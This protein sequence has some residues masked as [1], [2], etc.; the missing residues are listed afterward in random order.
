MTGGQR[1]EIEALVGEVQAARIAADGVLALSAELREGSINRVME[2][3]DMEIG[4]MT[5][6]GMSPAQFKALKKRR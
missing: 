5:I 6:L 2:L 1:T 3:S 4:L